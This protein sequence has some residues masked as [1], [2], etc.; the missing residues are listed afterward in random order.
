MQA[1]QSVPFKA[2]VGIDWA[3]KKHDVCIQQAGTETFEFDCVPHRPSELDAW[4]RGLKKH[5]GSPIAVGLEL[6]K[7]P[8]VY[9]LQKH[10]FIVLYPI[11]PTMLARYR[12]A[13]KPSK[14]KDDPTDAR[15]ALELPYAPCRQADTDSAAEPENEKA[16]LSRRASSAARQ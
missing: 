2:F 11:N 1:K 6:A 5:F 3:D 15:I 10:D 7:G 14:A 12:E 9:A 13:F 4:A 16:R 8:L